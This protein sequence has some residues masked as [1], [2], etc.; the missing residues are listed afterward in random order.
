MNMR[1]TGIRRELDNM[2]RLTV[3][4][5]LMKDMDLE[6]GSAF[7]IYV[8]ADL[9]SIILKRLLPADLEYCKTCGRVT[10]HV[11]VDKGAKT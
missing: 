10:H 8:S 1:Y 7:D 6:K 3:P 5:P 9:T 4:I 2:G 11:Y